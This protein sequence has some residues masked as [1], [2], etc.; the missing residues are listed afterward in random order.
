M[1]DLIIKIPIKSCTA[2]NDENMYH[3]E[4]SLP[5]MVEKNL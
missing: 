4:Q 1:F 5:L 3:G 2:Y